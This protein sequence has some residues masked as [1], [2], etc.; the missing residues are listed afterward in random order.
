MDNLIHY[1]NLAETILSSNTKYIKDKKIISSF[2]EKFGENY[3]IE[4]L[5]ILLTII[6]SYYSTNMSKRYFGIEEISESLLKISNNKEGLK[7][8]FKSFLNNPS[9]NHEMFYLFE[10]NYGCKKNGQS[11]GK[12]ISLISKFAYFLLDY[13]FPIYDSVAKEVLPL[14][15][16]NGMDKSIVDYVISIKKL[17]SASGINDYN[18]LDNLIWLIGKIN[19]GNYSLLIQKDKYLHLVSNIKLQK[20]VDSEEFD[21]ILFQYVKDNINFLNYVFSNDQI[22]MI[23]FSF[24]LNSKNDNTFQ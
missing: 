5:Q 3:N 17:N 20:K 14:I 6:D 8:C 22:K 1:S 13:Q 23:T 10:K 15:S 24:S 19:R 11:G 12:A 7:H 2:F 21:R 9:S 16:K 4:I 18:K